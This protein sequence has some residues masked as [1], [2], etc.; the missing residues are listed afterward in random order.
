MTA[1]SFRVQRICPGGLLPH[2]PLLPGLMMFRRRDFGPAWP[3]T[4]YAK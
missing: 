2:L 1:L 3:L 4:L